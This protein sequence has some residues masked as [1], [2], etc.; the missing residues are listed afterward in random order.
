M[1]NMLA[2]DFAAFRSDPA[3][4][5]AAVEYVG[6]SITTPGGDRVESEVR[7]KNPWNHMYNGANHGYAHLD[8]DGTRLV[9]EYRRSDVLDPNGGTATFER[10]VQPTGTNSPNRESV[11]PP[12]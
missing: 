5:A 10:F 12:V 2:S 3:H 11:P 6:G 7:A 8:A 9:T 1:V 4:H